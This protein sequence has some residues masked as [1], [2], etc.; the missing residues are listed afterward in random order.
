MADQENSHDIGC[1]K[2]NGVIYPYEKQSP[3]GKVVIC[4]YLQTGIMTT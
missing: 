3:K 1:L 4:P 2:S